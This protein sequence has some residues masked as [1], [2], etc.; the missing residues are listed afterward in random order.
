MKILLW[1][2]SYPEHYLEHNK[3]TISHV[4]HESSYLGGFI[5][6]TSQVESDTKVKVVFYEG[7]KKY[8]NQASEYYHK[9]IEF[10][11]VSHKQIEKYFGNILFYL[12]YI[13]ATTPHNK[14]DDLRLKNLCT[15]LIGDFKPE[16]VYGLSAYKIA[17]IFNTRRLSIDQGILNG[18]FNQ[19]VDSN[20]LYFIPRLNGNDSSV[21]DY[22]DWECIK[23]QPELNDV[24]KKQMHELR[25]SWLNLFKEINPLEEIVKKYR[26]KYDYVVL[27][28]LS[29]SLYSCDY[30]SKQTDI[31]F[32][33]MPKIPKNIGV[34]VTFHPGISNP[35]S[36]DLLEFLSITYD[37]II[38]DEE[39]L[40]TK[41]SSKFLIHLVDG[42]IGEST[43]IILVAS[44][45]NY[46][47]FYINEKTTYKELSFN[48]SKI[49][50]CLQ[51]VREKKIIINNDKIMYYLLTRQFLFYDKRQAE[52]I[53]K[54]I[55]NHII[56]TSEQYINKPFYDSNEIM[57][58]YLYKSCKVK[59]KNSL[60]KK[61]KEVLFKFLG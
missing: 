16:I 36:K 50:E 41:E 32:E 13:S 23:K 52:N 18:L 17:V 8:L 33:S 46:I 61:I 39:I 53:Y 12:N 14:E 10:I 30:N 54:I 34:I 38:I 47:C 2:L 20:S 56:P 31:L 4:L 25:K 15:D 43:S 45:F 44:L 7:I 35:P 27:F 48:I 59:N 29:T 6:Y 37:N 1:Y 3:Q 58:R 21:K 22:A 57:Q 49:W 26:K 11:F 40:N 24:Q 5:K 28:P 55:K 42:T 51:K 9:N 60:S 19:F